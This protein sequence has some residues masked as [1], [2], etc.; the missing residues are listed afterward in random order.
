MSSTVA[1][2]PSNGKSAA[3]AEKQ[4]AATSSVWAAVFLTVIKL[5]VGFMTG[6]LGMLAE[7]AHS[8]LDLVAAVVTFLAVRVSDR[9]ADEH[10]PYGHGK[11]ENFSALIETLLLVVT[12]V[13]IVYESIQRLFVEHVE[14]DANVWGFIVM[15]LSIVINVNRSRMLY[16]HRPQARQPGAGG[17]RPALLR[18]TSGAPGS[19]SAASAWSGWG[20]TSF[21]STW[22]S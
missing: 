13:W 17:R 4:S 21:P 5:I 11:V 12:C 14:V 2:L 19:S 15:A 20:R 8:G 7:A 1:A 9:P 10:H 3:E 6:S 18:P 16:R 22:S